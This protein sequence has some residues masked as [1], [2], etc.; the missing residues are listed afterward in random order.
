MSSDESQRQHHFN[1]Q[2]LREN[3]TR[4]SAENILYFH[5]RNF[6]KNP[7]LFAFTFIHSWI[8][9]CTAMQSKATSL[10]IKYNFHVV[11]LLV[12]AICSWLTLPI[13]W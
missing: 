4:Y 11:T 1:T 8:W 2:S 12:N 3:M 10:P 7:H 6:K 5:R 9:Y 13:I